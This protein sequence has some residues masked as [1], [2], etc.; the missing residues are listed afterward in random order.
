MSKY[1]NNKSQL[2][3]ETQHNR[4][5]LIHAARVYFYVHRNGAIVV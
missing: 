3:H 5:D 1:D 4:E 2:G